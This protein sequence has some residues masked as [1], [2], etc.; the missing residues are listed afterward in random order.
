VACPIATGA[1]L[2]TTVGVMLSR[3][4]PRP[5]LV[6]ATLL[7][8]LAVAFVVTRSDGDSGPSPAEVEA[9]ELAALGDGEAARLGDLIDGKPLV[10]NFFA[11]WC[12]PCKREMPDFERVHQEL[13]DRV[14]MV[15]VAYPPI[16][17][18]ED[19][20]ADSGV[21]YPTFADPTGE[22]LALFDGVRLPTTVFIASDGEVV[23]VENEELTKDEILDHIEDDLGVAP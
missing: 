15:G 19:M 6:G 3:R 2:L 9:V 21:T 10:L 17:G 12:A 22:V 18:A 14:G 8:L 4:V 1:A 20:V 16:R 7:V 11:K 23:S 5:V 13:G